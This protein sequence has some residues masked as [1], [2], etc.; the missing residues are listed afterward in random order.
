MRRAM[1]VVVVAMVVSAG[2]AGLQH[3]QGVDFTE[4]HGLVFAHHS[5]GAL[6]LDVFLPAG[7]GPHPAVVL[8]H[9]GGW[10]SGSRTG[11]REPGRRL[12]AG[13]IAAF[14]VDYRL[15]GTAAFPAASDDLRAAI[16][17][18]RRNAAAF[19]VDSAR[20]GLLGGSA[21]A[22]LALV[23]AMNGS[24]SLDSGERVA[25]VVAWSPPVDLTAPA[26]PL[27]QDLTAAYL[28]CDP[29]DCPERA[30][31]ASA[32]THV[33]STDPPALVI[34][35]AVEIVP[36]TEAEHLVADLAAADVHHRLVV[37]PGGAHASAY[38]DVVWDDTVEFL[39]THLRAPAP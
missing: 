27:L 11:W 3:A 16:R 37:L 7:R 23:T 38:R 21:G 4:H 19:D 29:A 30:S 13:G 17:W 18:V 34:T 35:S 26:N 9:G 33:D 14:A 22:N 31:A 39:R 28:G 2:A 32:H 1:A 15:S 25:A 36:V 12:A 8:V 20:I 5:T 6:S 10:R 24:G